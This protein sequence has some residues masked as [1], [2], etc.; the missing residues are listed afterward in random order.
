MR[1][2]VESGTFRSGLTSTSLIESFSIMLSYF[3]I[4]L[5]V[6]QAKDAQTK[7]TKLI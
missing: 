5:L 7:L 1:V 3:T 4:L 2:T 6:P